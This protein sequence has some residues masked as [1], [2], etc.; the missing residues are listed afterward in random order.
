MN[1]RV[2][3]FGGTSLST[4]ESRQQAA[5]HVQDAFRESPHVVVVVSAMG[6]LGD[7]YATDT[8]LQHLSEAQGPSDRDRDLLMACGE[9]ISSV[10]FANQLRAQ[11]IIAQP[12]TGRQAGIETDAVHG[13]ASILRVRPEAIWDAWSEGRVPVVAGF[14]GVS[15]RGDVTTLGRGGS[16]TTAVAVGVAI[17]ADTLDIFTDVAGVMTADPR[18]VPEACC[19]PRLGYQ[20]MYQFAAQGAKVVHPRAVEMAMAANVPMRVRKT[21]SADAGT[22]I[23]NGSGALETDRIANGVVGVTQREDVSRLTVRDAG[24]PLAEVLGGLAQPGL[25]M[26]WITSGGGSVSLVAS[27]EHAAT[28][29]HLLEGLNLSVRVEDGF[30]CVAVVGRGPDQTGVLAQAVEA[31]EQRAIDIVQSGHLAQG[32][33]VLVRQTHMVE[34]VRTLH[35]AFALEEVATPHPLMG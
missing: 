2:L 7:P 28:A 29:I 21:G 8:L 17:G 35:R 25:E 10:V 31:L 20:N 11:G 24:R 34:A 9:T 12:L 23:G 22:M 33:G 6:R 18:I 1:V 16:D 27:G 3:K 19:I 32:L 14:Q 5:S 26:D 15:S 13:N 4:V 30:S